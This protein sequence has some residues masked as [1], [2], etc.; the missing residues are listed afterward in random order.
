MTGW[1]I[2]G[3]CAALAFPVGS[4]SR[5]QCERNDETDWSGFETALEWSGLAR[6]DGVSTLAADLRTGEELSL[7][8]P[9]TYAIVGGG[10][11]GPRVVA[12]ALLESVYVDWISDVY[13]LD[14]KEGKSY[15]G[16]DDGFDEAQTWF[17][18]HLCKAIDRCPRKAVVV[19]D[20]VHVLKGEGIRLLDKMLSLTDGEKTNMDCDDRK[21][22]AERCLF[23]MLLNEDGLEED[24][25]KSGKDRLTALWEF[26]GLTF[27]TQA[28]VGRIDVA[29]SLSQK[30][31][32]LPDK[33][34]NAW[35]QA[36][37]LPADG[38]K[39]QPPTWVKAAWEE[40]KAAWEE[41]DRGTIQAIGV[42]AAATML[43]ACFKLGWFQALFKQARPGRASANT[44]TGSGGGGPGGD[45]GNG[46]REIG[47]GETSGMRGG[48]A[49]GGGTPI[50]ADLVGNGE[51]KEGAGAEGDGLPNGE[52]QDGPRST[53]DDSCSA[54]PRAA[55]AAE[56]PGA[57]ASPAAVAVASTPRRSARLE[58]LQQPSQNT[59]K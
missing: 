47:R 30:P 4:L 39:V 57:S 18:E 48:G 56:A 17:N 21:V 40:M 54:T 13:L 5:R 32:R 2:L 25:R 1:R 49:A 55:P 38:W 10:E 29:V 7:P 8:V 35:D 19:L 50:D 14:M 37:A 6:E 34:K 16:N 9:H 41:T 3:L 51:E 44:G 22:S 27:T 20:N 11:W 52:S 24:R 45:G 59:R 36:R 28:F 23:L 12:K 15:L 46:E 33:M 26:E 43:A 53:E 31:K 42:G 58:L